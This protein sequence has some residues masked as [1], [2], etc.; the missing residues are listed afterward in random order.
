MN[1]KRRP[2]TAQAKRRG[3]RAQF[4]ERLNPNAA[5]IDIGS[6]SHWVAVPENR[7]DRPVR[8]FSSFTR[9]LRQLAD[10]L[11]ACRID[12]V[13]MESTGV[14]WIPLYE[15]LEARGFEVCLVNARHVKNVPGRKTD[16][17]DCQWLQRLHTYGLLRASF[18]PDLEIVQ[19][20]AYVRHRDNLIRYAG[21]HVQHMQKA[22]SL[23]NVQLHKAVTDI[24][25][26]TGMAIIRDIVSGQHD[27]DALA[28]HRHPRCKA[29]RKQIADALT[30]NYQ[31]EHLFVLE[32]ALQS[33]DHY[34]QMMLKTD[35]AIDSLLSTLAACSPVREDPLPAPRT[36]AKPRA[37]EPFFEVR[38]PLYAI[39]G[40]DLTQIDGIGPYSALRLLSEIGHDMNRWPSENHFTSWLTLAP[41][42]RL[43]GGKLLS[44]KTPCSCNRAALL[45]RMSAMSVARTQT[46]LGAFYRRLAARI[47]KAKAITATARKIAV[48]AYRVLKHGLHY[49]DPGADHYERN[50]RLKVVKGLCRRA[51]TLGFHLVPIPKAPPST[52]AP[53]T[54]VS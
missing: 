31:P 51:K 4:V 54:A 52:A 13:C 49:R 12:T 16:V 37:N 6:R 47:G 10:W 24:T 48:M 26:Q 34:Q 23:M 38:S 1:N 3:H 21:A 5:G 35:H 44:S 46:S 39:T 28:Q 40:A 43:S 18:R 7:D 22:L 42:T 11:A 45:F 20:R 25:G 53:A 8:E 32:Q 9:D 50:Y 30:G 19:L 27:P 33:Y 17:L 15:L 2:N 36:K 41:G 14:Y 29:S